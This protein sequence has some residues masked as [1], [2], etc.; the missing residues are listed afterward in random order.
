MEDRIPDPPLKHLF[1]GDATNV[2]NDQICNLCAGTPGPDLLRQCADIF[3]EA[4]KHRMDLE[5][6]D[7]YLFQYGA[8]AGPYEFREELSRFLSKRY[9]DA[10]HREDLILT[11]GATHG[12][13]LILNSFLEPDGVIFVEEVTYMIA[14][15]VFREFSG[16]KIVP[17]PFSDTGVVPE[18]LERLARREK[19]LRDASKRSKSP[20]KPFWAVFYSIPVHHNPTGVCASEEVCSEVVRVARA[21]DFLVVCDDVYNLLHYS[22]AGPAPRRLFSVDR[23]L[24]G[25]SASAAGHVISNGSFSKILAPGVRVGWLEAPGPLVQ[26]LRTS[27]ILRSGGGVNA[28]M[29]GVLTS[30]LQL[31]LLDTHLDKLVAVLKGRMVALCSALQASLPEGCSLVPPAG[32]YFV[33]LRLPPWLGAEHVERLHRFARDV[34]RVSAFP[35]SIFTP[36]GGAPQHHQCLRLAVAFHDERKLVAAA[37]D[38]CAAIAEFIEREAPRGAGDAHV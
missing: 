35:G 24:P 33:W 14:I 17:V 23:S 36:A 37:R 29:A 5:R 1:D 15:S 8:T 16:L 10:V 25:A 30:A 2:Y 38:L 13:Q 21:L 7:A 6:K 12:L 28:Y 22:E 34:R 32:G 9:D 3:E 26:Q 19:D 11:C 20:G 27:G 4:T 18:E 31:G